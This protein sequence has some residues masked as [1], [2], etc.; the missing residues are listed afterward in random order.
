MDYPIYPCGDC[1]ITLQ[2]GAEISE[3]V[4]QEVVN[5][6][7]SI[8]NADIEGVCELVPTYTS[9]CIHYDPMVLSYDALQSRLHQIEILCRRL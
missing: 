6:L 1:A 9:I 7:E 5:A 4:N 2:I 3:E 8:R